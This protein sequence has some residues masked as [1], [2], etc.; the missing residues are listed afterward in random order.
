MATAI[1]VEQYLSH[2]NIELKLVHHRP[3]DSSFN[4]AISAH[5]PTTKL[6]K[7]V[8]LKDQQHNYL[9]AV[10]P[11]N[12]RVMLD[13]VSKI[14]GKQYCLVGEHELSALFQDCRPGAIPNLG[15][16]YHLDMI[17]DDMLFDIENIYLEAGDHENLIHLTT[18]QF[19]KVMTNISHHTISG[20]R[21]LFTQQ[22]ESSYWDWE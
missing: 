10:I 15:Q 22:N 12:R 14:T 1:S 5:V 3:T 6:A 8:I 9:M 19:K 21:M 17:V 4:S 11:A 7:S 16:I 13:K 2:H 20:Y 18:E